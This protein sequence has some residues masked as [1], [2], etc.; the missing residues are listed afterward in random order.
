MEVALD[1]IRQAE[2][3]ANDLLPLKDKIEERVNLSVTFGNTKRITLTG[4][5]M[6]RIVLLVGLSLPDRRTMEGLDKVKLSTSSIRIPSSFFTYDNLRSLFSALLKLRYHDL[7]INWKDNALLSRVIA[8]EMYRGRDYLLKEG[9]IEKFLFSNGSTRKSGST[10][11]VLRLIIGDYGDDMPAE[12]DING[13]NVNNAQILIA[14]ATGSGKSNLIA[15]LIHQFRSLSVDT[16]YPVNFLL[17]DYKG[18]FSDPDNRS[19]LSYFDVDSTCVLDPVRKPLPF[20]PFKDLTGAAQNQVNLYSTEMASALCAIG[21]A[22]IGAKMNTRLSTAIINAYSETNGAPISFE[23][24]LKHY[25]ELMSSSDGEDSITSVLTELIRSHLFEKQDL[26]NLTDECFII[27]LDEFPKDG[28]IAKA[29]VYFVIS[30]LNIIYE[31][32]DVQAKNDE[33]VQIRHFTIIDEAHY[34]LDFDN[35]PLR[36][37]IAVG[38]NKGMSIILATQN[39]ASFQSKYFDFYANAQYPLIMKQQTLSDPVIKD[40]FGVNGKELQEIRSAIANLQ[41]GELIIKNNDLA[42]LGVMGKKYKKIKV[43]HLI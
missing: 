39:M 3:I 2:N 31:N 4:N 14:G 10:L 23:L 41:L 16:S 28:A 43:S 32:L 30:K 38:R 8:M 12:L 35:R 27:K 15:V 19:W 21:R 11:P 33:C 6:M 26:V 24:M 5:K 20:S 22:S 18:E 7:Q 9:N 29:I 17:F 36:N 1:N 25:R 34:M 13:R 37:L 40:L 42:G